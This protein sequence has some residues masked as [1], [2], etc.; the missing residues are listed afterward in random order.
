MKK[1][2]HSIS[3]S[4][5]FDMNN[6]FTKSWR[7]LPLFEKNHPS[8]TTTFDHDVIL[9]N[10]PEEFPTDFNEIWEN[11]WFK[12]KLNF[13]KVNLSKNNKAQLRVKLSKK[14]KLVNFIPFF[15]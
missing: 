11:G 13:A 9:L 15:Q 7:N 2:Y 4:R 8:S 6:I 10:S 5:I 3:K 14:K 12:K 1:F